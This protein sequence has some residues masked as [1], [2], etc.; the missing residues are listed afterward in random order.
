MP[1]TRRMVLKELAEATDA[2]REETTTIRAL[3]EALQTDE[4]TL[5]TH[6]RG[7]EAC[8]LVRCTPDGRVRVT[9]TGEELL[10]LDTKD[11]VIIDPARGNP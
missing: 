10:Q 7:L 3:R 4:Q 1:V 11:V 2:S 5:Q 8:D 6:L 9:I